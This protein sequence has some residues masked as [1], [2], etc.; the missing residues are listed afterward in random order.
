MKLSKIKL[1]NRPVIIELYDINYNHVKTFNDCRV[2]SKYIN[3]NPKNLSKYYN[4]TKPYKN[5]WFIKKVSNK[6]KKRISCLH[7]NNYIIIFN[8]KII[9]HYDL[10]Y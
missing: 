1:T 2:L 10:F 4:N 7:N 9:G 3:C 5:L 8:Y 6:Y